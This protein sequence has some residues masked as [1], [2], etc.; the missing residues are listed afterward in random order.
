MVKAF[1]QD[2]LERGLFPLFDLQENSEEALDSPPLLSHHELAIL[3]IDKKMVKWMDS[4]K[5]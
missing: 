3:P 4:I 1:F 5:K 2:H